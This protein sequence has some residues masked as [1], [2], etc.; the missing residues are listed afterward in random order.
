MLARTLLLS[1]ALTLGLAL[2]PGLCSTATAAPTR[3]GKELTVQQQYDLGLKYLQRGNHAKALETFNRIRNYH[4]DDPLA[5]KA[6]LAVADVHFR[7]S[8][9]DLARLAYEDFMR[10]HP[11][12]PDIDHVVY[13]IGM[14]L[15]RKAPRLAARDQTWTRQAVNTW[16]GFEARFPESEHRVEVAE[17]YQESRERL[18]RKELLIARF[19]LRREAWTAV[20]GRADG[21]V[22]GWPES[23]STPEAWGLLAVAGAHQ[24]DQGQVDAALE[25]VG[26]TDPAR[27][28]RLRPR[29]QKALS[30]AE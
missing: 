16:A 3:R 17:R 11:R 12:H 9:W 14:S 20:S 1:L 27:A 26:K 22:K 23:A 19:Y 4:R 13:R 7:K 24:G 29:T 15:Y 18:A 25:Q 10:M 6:E 21:L 30:E 8:D 5:I 2:S 28:E